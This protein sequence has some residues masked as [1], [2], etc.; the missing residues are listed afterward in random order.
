MKPTQRNSAALYRYHAGYHDAMR[1]G[2]ITFI[3]CIKTRDKNHRKGK[4]FYKQG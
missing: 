1:G 3:M 4:S 2:E